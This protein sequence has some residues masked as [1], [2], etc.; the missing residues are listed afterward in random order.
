MSNN[1]ESA[2]VSAAANAAKASI[3]AGMAKNGRH[4]MKIINEMI[5]GNGYHGSIWHIKVS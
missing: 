3:S 4:E 1:G 2:V 5:N